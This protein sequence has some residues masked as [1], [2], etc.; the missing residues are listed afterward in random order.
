MDPNFLVNSDLF[1]TPSLLDVC[2]FGSACPYGSST[3]SF[4]PYS[5]AYRI[6][7]EKFNNL[8]S[9]YGFIAGNSHYI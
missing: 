8:A 5:L 3:C 2:T 9:R 6:K 1:F 7:F 4:C